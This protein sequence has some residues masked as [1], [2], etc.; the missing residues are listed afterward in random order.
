MTALREKLHQGQVG[1]TMY[2]PDAIHSHLWRNLDH[3][4]HTKTG[5]QVGCRQWIYHN[6]GSIT[7]F[8]RDDGGQATDEPQPDAPKTINLDEI[9]VEQLKTG[10]FVAKLFTSGPSLLTLWH[11]G[12]AI[13][14]LL[15]LKGRTHPADAGA[16]AIRGRFWCDN[17]VCNLL[18]SSDDM[19]EL[20]RELKALRLGHVLDAEPTF[21]RLADLRPV[22]KRYVG[23]SSIVILCEVINRMLAAMGAEPLRIELPESGDARETMQDLSQLLNAAAG[24]DAQVDALLRAYFAGDLATV[25]AMLPTLPVTSW[26]HFVLQCGVL[27]MDAWRAAGVVA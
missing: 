5:L 17:A 20:E 24:G 8:Y 10:H 27:S 25:T 26:E 15:R 6:V 23:H 16:E 14:Q 2:S 7:A 19:A 12:D 21:G 13:A 1:L 18:H 9:P 4:I 22:D 11:G 3:E